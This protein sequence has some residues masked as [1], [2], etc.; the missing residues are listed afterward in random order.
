M[1]CHEIV[2]GQ[3]PMECVY[4]S[5][6]PSD[7]RSTTIEAIDYCRFLHVFADSLMNRAEK[8]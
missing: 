7:N 1:T 2:L 3:L 5:S 8:S 6:C 4:N